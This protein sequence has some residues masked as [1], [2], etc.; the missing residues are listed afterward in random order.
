MDAV[1]TCPELSATAQI[2]REHA[3]AENPGVPS[4]TAVWV[5]AAEAANGLLD[6]M[7]EPLPGATQSETDGQLRSRA[8]VLPVLL[9][10]DA[11]ALGLL[12]ASWSLLPS[13]AKQADWDA[14]ATTAIDA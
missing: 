9:Q 5:Q 2:E 3:A 4:N 10:A 12:E 11:P 14:H 6:E 7:I 13:T 8:E 1:R